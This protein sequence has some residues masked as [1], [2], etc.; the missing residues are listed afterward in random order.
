MRFT[1]GAAGD[2]LLLGLPGEPTA[3]FTAYL[4]SRSPAPSDR[5]LVLG[6]ASDYVG[7]LLTAEDWLASG[8][9]PGPNVWGPLEG[10]LVLDGALTAAEIAWTPERE[11]PEAGS[12]RFV[13]FEFPPSDPV[14]PIATTDPG[15]VPSSLPPLFLPDTTVQPTGAQPEPSVPRIVGAARFVWLGGDPAVDFPE[16]VVERET[17][18]GAFEPLLD[19]S[20][21]PA[22][23]FDGA[24]V[25][26]YTPD[27]LDAEAPSSHY[28]AA[29]WQPV[30][31]DPF[32]LR[33]PN[34]PYGL[35]T[36][37]YRLK[38]VGTALTA[39][40]TLPY[41]IAS[42][43]FD[44]TVAPLGSGT[45][46]RGASQLDVSALLGTAPGLRALRDGISDRDVPLPAPWTVTVSLD[47]AST[48][49]QTVMPDGDGRG[50]VPLTA[51][52]VARAVAVEVRDPAGNGGVITV[53]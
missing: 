3:P 36:G 8:Y 27:P 10:E 37:R 11:D 34:A 20:G 47:D 52:D 31:P 7:Y 48:V 17:A 44:V 16:V 26:T 53:Q 49:V 18:P 6:Y 12:S 41:A 21:R 33:A 45:A 19:A 14:D 13:D 40:G 2:Y 30:P 38:A 9:E 22:S 29:T 4:R 1:G 46:T 32:S 24:V 15:T 28:Y 25:I 39:S 35:P 42:S 50:V 43:P 23:S 51:A 5:T